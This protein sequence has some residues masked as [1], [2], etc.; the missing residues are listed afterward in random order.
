MNNV[1]YYHLFFKI[2]IYYYS[3]YIVIYLVLTNDNVINFLK[4]SF[5]NLKKIG[6]N[7]NKL[8]DIRLNHKYRNIL[9]IISLFILILCVIYLLIKNLIKKLTKKQ[10][11]VIDETIL[12]K[13][14]SIPDNKIIFNEQNNKSLYKKNIKNKSEYIQYLKNICNN[15]NNCDNCIKSNLSLE[16]KI[17]N[18]DDEIYYN[19]NFINNKKTY[20]YYKTLNSDQQPNCNIDNNISNN[21]SNQNNSYLIANFIFFVIIL[22]C[23][24]FLLI[25]INSINKNIFIIK[26]IFFITLCIICI[27]NLIYNLYRSKNLRDFL[28]WLPGIIDI[29][30][31]IFLYFYDKYCLTIFV[32]MVLN[33]LN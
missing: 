26:L 12:N 25:N 24:N 9:K 17:N 6:S 19:C 7:K 15:Y 32:R 23:L 33:I 31:I 2:I 1:E 16:D 29:L 30:L 13:I 18:L 11:C 3:V 20:K 21:I 22:I 4:Y 5:L 8:Y 14:N 27:S 10:N 28:N